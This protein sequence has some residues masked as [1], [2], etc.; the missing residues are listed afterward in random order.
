[1]GNPLAQFELGRLCM[2]GLGVERND[3]EAVDWFR[4]AAERGH[5]DAQF[6]LGLM[7]EQ[8]R[9]V[10][11]NFEEAFR[12]YDQAADEGP[13]RRWDAFHRIAPSAGEMPE[14]SGVGAW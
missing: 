6:H 5:A 7:Y 10:T 11:R 3:A 1:M 8:G 12:W 4:L 14:G 9:G 2:E 13:V